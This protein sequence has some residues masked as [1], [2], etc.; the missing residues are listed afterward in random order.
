MLCFATALGIV[1]LSLLVADL[2][3]P[4]NGF[5]V[6]PV[7]DHGI[8]LPPKP[9]AHACRLIPLRCDHCF[10]AQA[11]RPVPLPYVSPAVCPLLL[12]ATQSICATESRSA[13]LLRCPPAVLLRGQKIKLTPLL[14]VIQLLDKTCVRHAEKHPESDRADLIS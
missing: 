2:D 9:T 8:C 11:C 14:E 4:Y 13:T 5:M 1:V 6:C 10:A 7:D 12:R 3:D